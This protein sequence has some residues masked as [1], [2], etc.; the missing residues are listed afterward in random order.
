MF[1]HILHRKNIPFRS[2]VP[3]TKRSFRTRILFNWSILE[4]KRGNLQKSKELV[5]SI[6]G[7]NVPEGLSLRY[8][9]EYC[10]LYIALED[11]RTSEILL[12]QIE[13][14]TDKN[15]PI[16]SRV[17]SCEAEADFHALSRDWS[18]ALDALD[19][20]IEIALSISPSNDLLAELYRRKA[21]VLYEIGRDD[22]SYILAKK[23]L[24]ICEDVSEIY[25]M[26]A[27]F[28][29][30]GLLAERRGEGVEAESLLLRAVDFYRSKDEKFERAHSHR[31]LAH[32]YH[33]RDK[34][35]LHLA[36]KH[37]ASALSLFEEMGVERRS[38]EMQ[39][40]L[41]SLGN[42]IP[43][44]PFIVPDGFQLAQI[45]EEHGIITGDYAMTRL[46]NDMVRVAQ[47][48][49]PVLIS[50]ETGTGKELVAQ[51]LHALSPRA[52]QALIVVNC[53]AI[54]TELLESEIFGHV[55]GSFTGAMRD[56]NGKF[57]QADQ[58]TL[59]LDEIGDLNTQLQ[60]KLLRVLQDGSFTPVGSDE[61]IR[62]D[63][64]VL[65]ASNRDLRAMV[66]EGV[67]RE[68]LLYR[69]NHIILEL[70]PL[71]KRGGDTELLLRYFMHRE[72]ELLGRGI[73]IDSHALDV[74]LAYPWPGN[75][76]ELKSFVSQVALYAVET[77]RLT[78]DLIPERYL[79]PVLEQERDLAAIVRN[80]EKEA[81]LNAVARAHGNKARAARDL[82]V[83]R[84]TLNDKITR[85]EI[86]PEIDRRLAQDLRRA[87]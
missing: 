68:D 18:R 11:K 75:V 14:L 86:Q 80:A 60:A 63:V 20:G 23:A 33:R 53:A 69:L 3:E 9:N 4:R 12:R 54:P 48:P 85:L 55:R 58:G 21:R 38:Q 76:R 27:L 5:A 39:A 28:R 22:E 25:E 30:L 7:E 51:A 57:F 19:R 67:F 31:E 36:F 40:L 56:R 72:S 34:A 82:G 16:R 62:A 24:E 15:T 2:P 47:S 83:S 77:G 64:R 26:G 35:D 78:V 65:S 41:D 84:S 8:T 6:Q 66:A 37:A 44:R 32:F 13:N 73:E 43:G 46:L 49:A 50:G 29:T 52:N 81:I 71:R 87:R 74:V 61:E 10:R 42:Q 1:L 45:G 70:P 79:S 17:I 59:F